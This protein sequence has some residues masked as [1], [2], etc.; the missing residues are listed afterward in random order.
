MKKLLLFLFITIN[1][2]TLN[3]CSPKIQ[4]GNVQ[5]EWKPRGQMYFV[6]PDG[7]Y[8]GAIPCKSCP[9]I[10]V[11]LNFDKNNSV[12]KDMRYIQSKNKNTRQSGTWVVTSGNIVQVT[13]ANN[14]TQEFYKAQNGGHLIMLNDKREL[15][16]NPSQAQFFIFN[17][18]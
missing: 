8:K 1:I 15:N 17:K 9:G 10:E 11:T 6:A 12:V 3:G 16:I 14:S 2:I 13:Y 7:R 4:T 5:T 18:D